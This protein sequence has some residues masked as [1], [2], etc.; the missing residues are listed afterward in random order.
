[1]DHDIK[2]S[3]D[4]YFGGSQKII[5]VFIKITGATHLIRISVYIGNILKMYRHLC[6]CVRS[7]ST[8]V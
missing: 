2:I 8:S 4:I 3:H 6:Q 5:K 7:K 1:M